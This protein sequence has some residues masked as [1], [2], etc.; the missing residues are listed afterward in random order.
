MRVGGHPG[1]SSDGKDAISP[2][3]LSTHK[4]SIL[5]FFMNDFNTEKR[6]P[7]IQIAPARTRKL[8]QLL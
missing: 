5:Q 6:K 1:P 3:M 2:T 7:E 8:T 4:T